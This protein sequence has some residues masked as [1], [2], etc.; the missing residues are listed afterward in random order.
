VKADAASARRIAEGVET[1][2]GKEAWLTLTWAFR[3]AD[4]GKEALL[5]EYIR[6]CVRH[7]PRTLQRLV[8][9][10]VRETVRRARGVRSE[11]HRFVGLLRFQAVA[12]G[13]YARFEPD[14]DVLGMLVGAFHDRMEG[15]DW[16]LHDTERQ[17]AW[18][19]RQGV[20]QGVS[21]VK[22]PLSLGMEWTE[23]AAQDLWKKYFKN[24]AIPD[25]INPTVQRGR[26]PVKTWKNLVEQPGRSSA[27]Y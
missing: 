27:S 16:M 26:M 14:H 20:G 6:L 21:G 8:D 2:A 22:V 13:W 25:R 1:H 10:E 9:P 23:A 19:C 12:G 7:G 17:K 18:I 5:A 15:V 3:H 24:I 11:A 4:R